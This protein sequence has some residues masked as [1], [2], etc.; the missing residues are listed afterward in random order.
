MMTQTQFIS[1]LRQFKDRSE[2]A[3]KSYAPAVDRISDLRVQSLMDEGMTLEEALDKTIAIVAR[4]Y[5][6]PLRSYP[7]Q[8]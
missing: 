6:D 2:R 7:V 8:S 1:L 3:R 4:E 5:P